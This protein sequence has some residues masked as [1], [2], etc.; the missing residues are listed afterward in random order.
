MIATILKA[1]VTPEKWSKLEI[2]F[3]K[4]VRVIP[5]QLLHTFLVQSADDPDQWQIITIWR[6]REAF[7]EAHLTSEALTCV[8]MFHQAGVEPERSFYEVIAH[9]MHV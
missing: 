9:H 5:H 1:R 2:A 4:G 6:S 3:R 7:N 8:G